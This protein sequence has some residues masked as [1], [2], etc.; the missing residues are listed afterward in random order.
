MEEPISWCSTRYLRVNGGCR[1]GQPEQHLVRRT[2]D[3][4][5]LSPIVDYGG[6]HQSMLSVTEQGGS[7]SGSSW[8][9]VQ[10]TTWLCLEQHTVRGT[11]RWVSAPIES[12]PWGNP[13]IGSRS[14]YNRCV[15][16][17]VG[18]TLLWWNPSGEASPCRPSRAL[19]RS[20]YIRFI[21]DLKKSAAKVH[22]LLVETYYEA[23]L[24]KRSC[25]E[26]FQKFKN[27]EFD[28]EDKERSE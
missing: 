4:C 6:T 24:S 16:V 21:T 22:R 13:S 12:R 19:L 26:W 23:A 7:V 27:G 17:G 14:G 9:R 8:C 5:Q 2:Y 10:V 15:A 1:P 25:C 20:A 18:N 28:I 3:G 11:L